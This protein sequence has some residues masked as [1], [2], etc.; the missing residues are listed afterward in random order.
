[1]PGYT[2]ILLRV[3]ALLFTQWTCEFHLLLFERWR[4][5]Y[6]LLLEHVERMPTLITMDSRNWLGVSLGTLVPVRSSRALWRVL[7]VLAKALRV[8]GT[9]T[10]LWYTWP[11]CRNQL[12]FVNDW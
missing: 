3:I 10:S 2:I 6:R 1:M 7:L 11:V 8:K 9:H 12:A 4:G 5:P